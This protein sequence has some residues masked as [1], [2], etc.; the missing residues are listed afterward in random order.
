MGPIGFY[1][2]LVISP[3]D[4]RLIGGKSMTEETAHATERQWIYDT[5]EKDRPHRVW[6]DPA[7]RPNE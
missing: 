3:T 7:G 1:P 5:G 2:K 4:D 6:P